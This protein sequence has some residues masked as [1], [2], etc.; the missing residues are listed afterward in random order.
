MSAIGMTT[1]GTACVLGIDG[2]GTSTTAWLADA[3]G[4]VLGRGRSGPSNI[5]AVG[6][7]AA[8]RSLGEATRAAR[9]EAGL[10]G[11][12]DAACLGVAGFDRADDRELL[13]SWGSEALD[14][15]KVVIVNDGELVFAAGIPDGFG[16]AVIAGTGSIAVGRD[17]AG[18]YAR[19]GGWGHLLGDEGSAYRCAQS[20]LTLV[21]RRADGRDPKPSPDPLSDRLCAA[22]GVS[23]PEQ[24]VS[25]IYRPEW[26]RTKI[27]G[28]T[29]AVMEAAAEDPAI[30]PLLLAP[31]G[32]DLAEQVAAVARR[33][34]REGGPLPLALAGSFLL[35]ADAVRDGLLGALRERGY[36]PAAVPVPDPTAG[37]VRLALRA[38]AA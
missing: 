25:A 10:T 23:S 26:D 14:A 12:L 4:N 34:G 36:V 29:R 22:F 30:A 21:A 19:A 1:A 2:G 37:A 28:L 8:F 24:I 13:G 7:E 32:R 6:R 3:S 33:L 17:G 20:A 18:N 5:K 38:I 16:V 15:R 27:A 31:A 9:E 11:S 35:N